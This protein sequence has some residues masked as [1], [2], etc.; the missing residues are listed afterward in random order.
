MKKCRQWGSINLTPARVPVTSFLP[1][2]S[3][4]LVAPARHQDIPLHLPSGNN[5]DFPKS[6]PPF[7]TLET[8]HFTVTSSKDSMNSSHSY[9][10]NSISLNDACS[11]TTIINWH[12]ETIVT[13]IRS[14]IEQLYF[15][16]FTTHARAAIAATLAPLAV[17]T[18]IT[19]EKRDRIYAI[20][21]YKFL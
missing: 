8:I 12:G 13:A 10:A 1:L 3:A 9:L 17:E 7:L 5:N 2:S 16:R 18:I 20:N 11:H 6:P 19:S 15:S 21:S 4:V 14:C